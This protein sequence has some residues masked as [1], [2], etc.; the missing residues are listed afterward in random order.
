MYKK[1]LTISRQFSRRVIDLL[2]R[3]EILKNRSIEN[4]FF[5][6][7][8]VVYRNFVLRSLFEDIVLKS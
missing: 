2:K 5:Q 8:R 3:F 6:R 7:Y 1:Y 4:Y